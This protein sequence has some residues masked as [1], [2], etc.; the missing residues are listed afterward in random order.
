MQ[1][2]FV[3]VWGSPGSGKTMTAVKIAKAL[4]DKKKNVILVGCDDETPLLP[5]LLPRAS[6]T[7]SLG[8]LLALP[9]LTQVAVFQHCVPFGKSDYISIL[10]YSYG[11]NVMSY[12]VYSLQ[13][14]KDLFFKLRRL[15]DNDYVIA[16]CSSHLN[17][18]DLTVAA[19]ECSDVTLKIVNADL[20]SLAYVNSQKKLLQDKRFDYPNQVNIINNVMSSQDTLPISEALGS[21]AC[22]LPH[23][24]ALQEQ[25]DTGRLLDTIFGREA[26]Q[27]IPAMKSMIKEVF[28]YEPESG[29]IRRGKAPAGDISSIA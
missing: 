29:I 21:V 7:Q 1:N 8:D 11:E 14:A 18:N 23:M 6:N 17:D 25:Y 28:E 15:P 22:T 26:K 10:G 20:I 5:L 3:A 19:L 9:K 13:Q 4:A 27:Y 24:D 2:K 16:D 12:P